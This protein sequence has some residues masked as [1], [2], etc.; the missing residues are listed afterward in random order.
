VQKKRIL[1]L[2]PNMAGGGAER[3]LVYLSGELVSRGWDIH[4]ALLKEGPNF[5][6]LLATGATVHKIAA[7]GN[8]DIAILW[9]IRQLIHHIRPHIVQTWMTQMD[10]FGGMAAR[11]T[12]TP[13]ILSERCSALAYPNSVKNTLRLYSGRRAV[14]IV[15]NAPAG[16]EYWQMHVDDSVPMYVV[17]NSVPLQ[18]IENSESTVSDFLFSNASK[19]LLFAGRF[20]PQ[21]NIETMIKAFKIVASR[22]D[23]VLLLCGEGELQTRIEEMLRKDNLEARVL[24]LGYVG[25]LWELMKR[26]DL[27]LT[28]SA[29]EGHPNAVLEAMA[30]GCPLVVSDI[31]EHRDFLDEEKAFLVDPA[32]VADI[33]SAITTCLKD[34]ER[35]KRT[36]QKAKAAVEAFSIRSAADQ[37]ETIYDDIVSNRGMGRR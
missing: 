33:A 2:I 1:H 16:K 36:A 26:A 35:A 15:S 22:Q 6:G 17:H 19:V 11:L 12:G 32:N 30:C 4:V 34:P 10:V 7:R 31:Q 27:F 9:R 20:T 21:K 5:D 13:F 14:A 29:F 24:I 23:V 37:Y 8:H 25:N 28:I 18:E 3:Q